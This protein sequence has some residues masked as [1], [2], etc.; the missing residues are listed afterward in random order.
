[1]NYLMRRATHAMLLLIGASALC[2]L[3]SDL[4][5]GSFFDEMKLNPQITPATVAVLRSQYGLDRPLPLRYV[6]WAKSVLQGE[7][8]YSFAYNVPVRRLLSERA[9]NTLILTMTA[10]ALAWLIAVPLGMWAASHT[11]GRVDRFSRGATSFLLCVPELVLVLGLLCIAIRTHAL[12]PGGMRSAGFEQFGLWA[13]LRDVAVH[14]VVPAGTLVLAG[15]P[16]LVRHVRASL[17]EVLKAPFMQAARGHGISQSRL[18]LRYALPAAAKP[19]ISLFGLSVGTLL[20][21][22]LL[23]EVVTGWPGLGPL[24]LEA[25]MSRDLYVVVGVVLSSTIFMVAGNL[26]ADFML[27]AVDPR[28]RLG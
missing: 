8:G 9:W 26:L 7:W 25:A 21:G 2:F 28:I 1:M 27:V 5:P 13:K 14:L 6:R 3:F 22:S 24:L 12:P 23:V 18:R 15:L 10:T 11:N 4:A 16:M 17:V 20:S 19:L